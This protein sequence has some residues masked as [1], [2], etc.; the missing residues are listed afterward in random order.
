MSCLPFLRTLAE[1]QQYAELKAA[2]QSHAEDSG[3]PAVQPLLLLAMAAL[4]EQ[5]A[6]LA[7][8]SQLESR[9]NSLPV[10]ARVDLAAGC[11]LLQRGDQARELL[12]QALAE[13]PDHALALARL[14]GCRR[15]QG[16]L[17]EA[18]RLYERSAELA[19]GRIAVHAAL[20]HIYLA[21][22]DELSAQGAIDLGI[23]RL[24]GVHA[25]LSENVVRGFT[26]QLRVLQLETWLA[27]GHEAQAEAWLERRRADLG[28]DEW[29]GLLLAHASMLAGRA[30]HAQAEEGLRAALAHV[31][32]NV[33]LYGQLA[34]LAQAQGRLAQAAG[35]LRHAIRLQSARG[36]DCTG[37]WIQLSSAC[38][39]LS[40][41]R[42]RHAA[43]QAVAAADALPD[44]G[45][46]TPATVS[47]LRA[48]ARCVLA[49]VESQTDHFDRA[50]ALFQEVLDRDPDC[51]SALQGLGQ[52]QMQR[53]R[54]DEA[55][56]LFERVKAI[57]PTRGHV[58]LINA[59]KFPDDEATLHR[60]EALARLPGPEGP[61]RGSLLFQLAAAWEKRKDYDRA[62]ALAA[63]ANA[64]NKRLLAYDARAHRQHCARIRH[65]YT[66]SLYEHRKDC[67]LDTTVPVYVVGMPRSGTTL[68]EQIL[69]GHSE[70]FGAGELGLIP[71]VIEGLE[72][73]ERQTGSG[74][75]YPDCVDDLDP[76]V[77]AGIAGQVLRQLQELGPGARFVV[78]K[79]PHNFENIG[80][81]KFLFPKA[82]I[83]SVRRDPRDIAISN[84]FTDFQA[85]HGGMGFA[86]DL[87]DIGEQLADHHLLMDHWHR[88]FPGEIL[89]V[90]YED[91][92]ADT[93]GMARRMLDHLGAAWEPGVLDFDTLDRTVKTASVWQV[94]QPIYTSSRNKWAR[95]REHLAPLIRGTNAKIE[96]APITDM[97]ALPEPGLLN[98]GV[99]H[100]HAGQLDQA[101]H[102][103][104][105]LLHHLPEHA[106][107]NFMVGL[108][109]V[110]KGHLRPGIE[111]M[112]KALTLC[113]W[114]RNWRHDL[115]Q[116]CRMI[117]EPERAEA[118]ERQGER[119]QGRAVA[120]PGGSEAWADG[121]LD[122][123]H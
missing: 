111:L 62:F 79:L 10:D 92:V 90:A 48:E 57:H 40:P 122:L 28:E 13:A 98:Q 15:Q 102:C 38:L 5:A 32:D 70:V 50:E 83:I 1:H 52:Q 39:H 9:L 86:Y 55:V 8:L 96:W 91:V 61:V 78:D 20:A 77:T 27:G 29:V 85:K 101:E 12:E 35:L 11:L 53:G 115:A 100:Y 56:A 51:L 105:R 67:G 65:A 44:S 87:T 112:E 37:W 42:A 26:A 34:E 46:A 18:R 3:D 31:P 119:G 25:G 30:R 45:E 64:A 33:A 7:L 104:K 123:S 23:R 36:A 95:Y 69:A 71:Q 99:A 54:I 6:A 68:V 88:L 63:E 59:R 41:D 117:G 89:E 19:P 22:G 49:A 80:L 60:I 114:N 106:A 66:R 103:F 43:E 82:K 73:W 17:A 121:E 4:G 118:L 93:E 24:E 84:F 14:A 76:E 74:R 97:V 75:H 72:R 107:A 120:A 58:A 116:A 21:Q 47:A 113:P 81:I 108:V 110:R 2:A 109:Y 16:D 94:R